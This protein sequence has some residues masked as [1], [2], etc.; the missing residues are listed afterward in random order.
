MVQFARTPTKI[1]MVGPPYGQEHQ[2]Y[3][4]RSDPSRGKRYSLSEMTPLGA[5]GT[6]RRQ[7]DPSR[8]ERYILAEMTPLGTRRIL[9]P[10]ST[11]HE[12]IPHAGKTVSPTFSFW[13]GVTVAESD[14]Q[15]PTM[16][17]KDKTRASRIAGCSTH[18]SVYP[19]V[20]KKSFSSFASQGIAALMKVTI[21]R[22]RW[23][24]LASTS[25]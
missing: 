17:L 15:Y 20:T 25:V 5:R 19:F 1:C 24:S 6:L 13:P 18:M 8:G 21:V 14:G 22:R 12:S 2:L 16:Y 23:T 3:S 9:L 11:R 4:R 10:R 7:D